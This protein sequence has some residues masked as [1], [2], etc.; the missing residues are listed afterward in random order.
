MPKLSKHSQR[1]HFK[2][3]R[4]SLSVQERSRASASICAHLSRLPE[5]ARAS[6]IAAYHA[7][8]TEVDLG[9]FFAQRDEILLPRVVGRQMT[10]APWRPGDPLETSALG[11]QEPPASADAKQPEDIQ[12][13]LLP[14][15]AFDDHG[16][17]LGMGGGYYDRYVT[18][19]REHTWR[20][21][22][23]FAIQGTE[24]L[25][26]DTWDAPLHAVITEQGIKHF[27]HNRTET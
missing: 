9:H 5:L 17:R 8:A 20:L 18:T 3:L 6:V 12:V 26:V 16:A 27:P 4:N 2:H 22:V 14:L 15:V 25:A 23:A 1:E 10:F 7:T 11:L 24:K 13:M 19:L 21:G